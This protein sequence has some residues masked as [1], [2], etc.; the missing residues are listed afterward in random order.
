MSLLAHSSDRKYTDD[1]M[2]AYARQYALTVI[3]EAANKCEAFAAV[4]HKLRAPI[5]AVVAENCAAAIRA[6]AGG[7][8]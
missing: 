6:M 4:S 7:E 5:S 3:E 2:Q 8:G 1:Q